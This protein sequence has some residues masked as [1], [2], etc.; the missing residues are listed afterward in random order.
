MP[1]ISV[2]KAADM[3]AK[4]V[5]QIVLDTR[6]PIALYHLPD[7][8]FATDDL[9]SHGEA[10]LAEGEIDEG[11]IVCPFHLGKFDIRSGAATASPCFEAI[12][13]Y[14]VILGPDGTLFIEL[15]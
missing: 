11:E 1:R 14:P 5:R 15:P 13:T 10:S 9:C 7:G 2:G 12:K 6:P 4:T 8:F 3:P